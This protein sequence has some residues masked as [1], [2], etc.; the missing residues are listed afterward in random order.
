[1]GFQWQA[2]WSFLYS[3]EEQLGVLGLHPMTHSRFLSTIMESA[4]IDIILK[5]FFKFHKPGFAT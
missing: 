5:T 1:M 4:P 2:G 3:L